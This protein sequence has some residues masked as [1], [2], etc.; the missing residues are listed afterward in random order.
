MD[1]TRRTL[2][3]RTIGTCAALAVSP[4]LRAAP[5][6]VAENDPTARALGYKAIATTADAKRFPKYQA[7]RN[8][9]ISQFFQGG[10]LDATGG[11]PMFGTRSVARNGWCNAYAKRV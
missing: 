4:A 8:C 9:A 7:D 6:G 2:I 3:I 11:C 1:A 10:P 5:S